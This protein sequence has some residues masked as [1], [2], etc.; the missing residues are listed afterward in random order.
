LSRELPLPLYRILGGGREGFYVERVD[1][2]VDTEAKGYDP[3]DSWTHSLKSK[4][5][6][7]VKTRESALA[8]LRLHGA[9]EY[10]DNAAK[11][12]HWDAPLT[13]MPETTA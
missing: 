5:L 13:P 6:A 8:V 2:W 1:A 12:W 9:T 4:L 3:E 7:V 10:H 11:G